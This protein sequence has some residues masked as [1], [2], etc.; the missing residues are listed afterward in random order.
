M[1]KII[2]N[3]NGLVQSNSEIKA[4]PNRLVVDPTKAKKSFEADWIHI[5]SNPQKRSDRTVCPPV[6]DSF[7]KSTSSREE[8]G[9]GGGKVADEGRKLEVG[10]KCLEDEL[11]KLSLG[12]SNI[13]TDCHANQISCPKTNNRQPR[14][15][16]HKK[17]NR[18]KDEFEFTN[19]F[20][21]DEEYLLNIGGD[22]NMDLK[23]VDSDGLDF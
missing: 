22:N 12:N 8:R 23:S 17:A 15:Y 19:D 7:L 4:P 13:S 3:T 18:P 16:R 20:W 14:W 9:V 21:E 11:S 1:V 5:T 2:N 10:G 6:Y